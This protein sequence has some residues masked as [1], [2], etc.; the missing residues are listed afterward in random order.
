MALAW[1]LLPNKTKASYVELFT[2]IRD[3]FATEFGVV[4]CDRTYL[5]DFEKAAIQAISLAFPNSGVKGCSFHFRL[6]GQYENEASP[7]RQWIR[8]LLSMAALPAVA[9]PLVWH[10]LKVPPSVDLVTDAKARALAA[11]FE[12]TWIVGDFPASLW[13]H[14]DNLGPRT[15]NVAESFHNG[16]NSR[17]GN[18]H[19]SLRLFL[20][21]LKREHVYS[22]FGNNTCSVLR[23]NVKRMMD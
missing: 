2:A 4:G 18:S 16:L 3:A 17:F 14:Y 10:W 20:Y 12:S 22:V 1:A 11:Y 5:T 15:T 7:I 6:T 23:L 13:T 8:E 19:P 9:V 21:T